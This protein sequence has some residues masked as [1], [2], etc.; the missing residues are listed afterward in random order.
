MS[1]GISPEFWWTQG[2]PAVSHVAELLGQVGKAL[3][4]DAVG[5]ESFLIREAKDQNPQSGHCG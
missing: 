2:V 5:W 1:P 4:T 3:C